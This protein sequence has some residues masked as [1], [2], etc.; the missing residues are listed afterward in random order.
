MS[1]PNH[2]NNSVLK[3]RY[4]NT[5]TIS[6][7]RGFLITGCNKP[8]LNYS[9]FSNVI[10]WANI[11][12]SQDLQFNSISSSDR[13][14]TFEQ[15]YLNGI[16]DHVQKVNPFPKLRV[17]IFF[18]RQTK[19]VW[20]K[21]YHF[22]SNSLSLVNFQLILTINLTGTNRI[23]LKLFHFLVNYKNYSYRLNKVKYLF[24]TS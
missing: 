12:A 21:K 19:T 3:Q 11:S 4:Q 9:N 20:F 5:S 22:C 6:K 13:N 24:M 7:M 14:Q 23:I 10:N 18:T 8:I 2:T 16:G 1:C 17:D 15:Y